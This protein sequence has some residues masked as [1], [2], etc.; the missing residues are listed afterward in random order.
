M[1][2][3]GKVNPRGGSA[4]G[5]SSLMT[6]SSKPSNA[7]GID[8]EREVQV[9]RTVA[10][11]LGVEV[12]LPQLAQRVR[13]D[14][15][16]LVVHVEPVV[17][18]VA[19]QFGDESGDIDDC[20]AR[21]TTEQPGERSGRTVAEPAY[22]GRRCSTRPSPC[23]PGCRCRCR[24]AARRDRLGPERPTRRPVRA[25]RRRRRSRRWRCSS[26]PGVAVLS[27]ESGVDRA[28]ATAWSSSIR[29]TG[30][31]TPAAACRGSP[32]RCAWSTSDGPAVALVVNQASGERIAAARGEGA[33]MR[34]ATLRAVGVH[35]TVRRRSSGISGRPDR[36]G[37][38]RS[39]ALSAPRA[40]DLCLVAGGSLDAYVDMS[41]DAH[42]VWDYLAGALVC[43]EAGCRRRRRLRPRPRC[44]R[45]RRPSHT[46]RRG[47]RRSCC[48][49]APAR[50]RE[51]A[52]LRPTG[53]HR[54]FALPRG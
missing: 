42:G 22:C 14:E 48:R 32:R 25:R 16:P 43:E 30:R 9:D 12:D 46:G 49:V 44:T 33:W 27:E 1:N 13:L 51:S 26:T 31:P 17:D 35:G 47:R 45:P 2:S 52:Q 37:T 21:D 18:G 29:S 23:S 19:L 3:S 5:S 39:S 24:G 28:P 4:S 6:S 10:R 53:L 7:R 36:R 40:L 20:H 15:V 8:L 50:R 54:K 41:V 11:L 38:G 34:R